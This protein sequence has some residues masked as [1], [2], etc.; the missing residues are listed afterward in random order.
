M[1]SMRADSQV[2]KLDL[3]T[4]DPKNLVPHLPDHQGRRLDQGIRMR[5]MLDPSARWE[6]IS[7]PLFC[8][9]RFRAGWNV[10]ALRRAAG[11]RLSIKIDR[12]ASN[13]RVWR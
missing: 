4:L 5:R 1:H 9:D 12:T 11:N 10:L 8:T 13:R 3:K 6:V 2:T 7:Y